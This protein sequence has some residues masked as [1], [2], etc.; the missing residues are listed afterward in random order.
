MK[1]LASKWLLIKT[2]RKQ[3]QKKKQNTAEKRLQ[4]KFA[5][6][7]KVAR[8]VRRRNKCR[9][10]QISVEGLAISVLSNSKLVQALPSFPGHA[11]MRQRRYVT[12]LSNTSSPPSS[13]NSVK[14]FLTSD[15][16]LQSISTAII[17][18][19]DRAGS[20]GNSTIWR[21]R[22]V[23]LPV[24]SSAP[25]IHNWYME[26]KMLSYKWMQWWIYF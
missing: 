1:Y 16:S 10:W 2:K 13:V 24:L 3:I 19:L 17:T 22:R 5:N 6:L 11:S 9:C 14:G 15:S 20:N 21:P 26:F 4:I 7:V 12:F 8:T 23:R 18:I 25:K